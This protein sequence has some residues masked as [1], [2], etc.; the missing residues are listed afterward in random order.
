MYFVFTYYKITK[1][2]TATVTVAGHLIMTFSLH[3]S[4]VIN[5]A[6]QWRF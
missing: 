6:R 2:N 5:R 1:V 3:I 4:L